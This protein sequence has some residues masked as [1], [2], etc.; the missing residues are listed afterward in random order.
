MATKNLQSESIVE[1]CTRC[2]SDHRHDVSIDLLTD[3][4][5]DES[6]GFGREPYRIAECRGCGKSTKTRLAD[7]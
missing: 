3:I 5:Q 2:G 4:D 6:A 7:A 1:K